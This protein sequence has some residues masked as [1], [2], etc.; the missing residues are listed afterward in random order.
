MI[1]YYSTLTKTFHKFEVDAQKAEDKY[2]EEYFKD[3]GKRAAAKRRKLRN[4][5]NDS[6]TYH[7][8]HIPIE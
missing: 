3:M 6:T 4:I 2:I 1:K 8:I 7:V 5:A